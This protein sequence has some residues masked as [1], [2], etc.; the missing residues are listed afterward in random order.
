M[1]LATR[2]GTTGCTGAIEDGYCVV[3]GAPPTRPAAAPPRP[4]APEP[5]R[6]AAPRPWNTGPAR[7]LVRM[8]VVPPQDPEDAV[9]ADPH[10]PEARR[11]CGRC[12]APVGRG[13]GGAP[14]RTEGF[15]GRCRAPYSFAPRL[16]R[17]DLV[18]GQYEVAGCLAHGGL[19]WVYL[20][21]DRHVADRWVVL[22]GL[23]DTG[24]ADALAAAAAE[25]RVLAE[26]EHPGI[27]KIYNFVRHAGDGHIVMEYAGGRSLR[28]LAVAHRAATGGPLPLPQVLAH[29]LDALGALGHLHERGLLYCDFKPANA[30]QCGTE[31]RLIDLGGVR[32]IGDEDGA[33]Y[34]TAGFQAPEIG[35]EAPSVASD[36]YTVGRT[37]AVLA[38]EFAGF[39]GLYRHSLPDRDRVPL[40]ARHESFDLLLRRATHPDPAARFA[41]AAEMAEQTA[42]VLREV[43]AAEEDRPVPAP[44]ARFGPETRA[45]GARAGALPSPADLAA[46]LPRPLP[47]EDDPAAAYLASLAAAT[48]AEIVSAL[49]GAHVDSTEVRQSL[50]HAR[51]VL[52][53]TAGARRILDGLPRDWRTL[54]YGALADLARG[55]AGTAAD[56]FAAVRALLPGELVPSLALGLCAELRTRASDAEPCYERV[57]TTDRNLPSAGFGLARVRFALGDRYAAVDALLAVPPLSR[58]HA[59]AQLGAV[60]ARLKGRDPAALNLSEL[61][62]CGTRVA[63]LDL[64]DG[65]RLRAT[66]LVLTAALGYVRA[67]GAPPAGTAVLGVPLTERDL[68]FGLERCYRSLARTTDDAARRLALVELANSARPHTLR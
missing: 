33:I 47:D 2:C 5:V 52:G 41:S 67:Q 44:S 10:V 48:P 27:V 18:A 24:D 6:A 58:H 16:R 65:R 19:G 43:L 8:P 17:G 45:P 20:A 3:C 9:L 36:L 30:V 55:A 14:G 26:V 23:R 59:E 13:Q 15:C 46:A 21:R 32:R 50:A 68:G 40:L 63:A 60:V 29:A 66:A 25:R 62:D 31:L 37:M 56:G 34:G 51:L 1:D 35:D 42:G 12:D 38:F 4:R 7:A 22:K 11:F 28:D 61:A 53:D 49:D 57:W 64:D 39:T 54:W